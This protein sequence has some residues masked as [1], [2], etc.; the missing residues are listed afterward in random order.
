MSNKLNKILLKRLSLRISKYEGLNW[1]N[2]SN[3]D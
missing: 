1:S 3:R 2:V